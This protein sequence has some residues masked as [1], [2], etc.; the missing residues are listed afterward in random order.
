VSRANWRAAMADAWAR[1]NLL[2]VVLPMDENTEAEARAV[3]ECL[4]APDALSARVSCPTRDRTFCAPFTA[5]ERPLWAVLAEESGCRDQVEIARLGGPADAF[6]GAIWNIRLDHEQNLD[7]WIRTQRDAMHVPGSRDLCHLRLVAFVTCSLDATR[8][9]PLPEG[10]AIERIPPASPGELLSAADD[11]V[12]DLWP[13]AEPPEHTF[14]RGALL[15]MASGRL[16]DLD[17]AVETLALR[18][19]TLADVRNGT[20]VAWR[21]DDVPVVV[22]RETL[23]GL[24][25][26]PGAFSGDGGTMGDPR[27][28]LWAAGLWLPLAD[29]WRTGLTR[30]AWAALT[31]DGAIAIEQAIL[32]VLAR[33]LAVERLCLRI[34]LRW[35]ADTREGAAVHE[36]LWID[37][38]GERPL[39]NRILDR[40]RLPGSPQTVA[41]SDV[42]AEASFREIV[43]LLHHVGGR[44][45]PWVV[46]DALLRLVECRN[47]AA[48]GRVPSL[49]AYTD[50]EFD[51]VDALCALTPLLV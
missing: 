15:D 30:R 7:S 1:A 43:N 28:L 27:G 46:S 42:L 5:D 36:A 18:A 40:A 4:I 44:R 22:A 33:C 3:R 10:V 11:A 21:D 6:Y 29:D 14:L 39:A 8:G 2:V 51:A 16:A 49:V 25:I 23:Q 24:G 13:D 47:N 35:S 9:F 50:M 41:V 45:V 12:A 48:H 34:L 20:L 32:D 31:T 38:F 19:L 26:T 17:A 37:R